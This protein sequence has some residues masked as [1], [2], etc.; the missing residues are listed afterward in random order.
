MSRH[1]PVAGVVGAGL[2]G[3]LGLI[4]VLNLVGWPSATTS[5]PN[6]TLVPKTEGPTVGSSH[7]VQKLVPHRRFGSVAV[8]GGG[9]VTGMSFSDDGVTRVVRTDVSGG[10]RWSGDRWVFD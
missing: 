10:Y 2:L 1:G 6:R 5:A 4:A 8:G 3:L 9:F 7:S